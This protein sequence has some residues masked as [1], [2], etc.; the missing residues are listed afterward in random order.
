MREL[1]L[2]GAILAQLVPAGG[3]TVEQ[4]IEGVARHNKSSK[5][6]VVGEL[7]QMEIDGILGSRFYQIDG[8]EVVIYFVL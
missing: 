3:S 5:E 8:S 6:E 2:H 4:I 1:S 7:R